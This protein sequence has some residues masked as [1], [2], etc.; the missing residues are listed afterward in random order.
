M[1]K[2]ITTKNLAILL[3]TLFSFGLYAQNPSSLWSRIAP[4]NVEVQKKEARSSL[5]SHFELFNLKTED[6]KA[7]LATAPSR[8]ITTSSNTIITLPTETGVERF[9]VFEASVLSEELKEKFPGIDSYVAQGIDD[10]SA[11]AR[12]SV[13]KVGVHV[14]ISSAHRS[15]YY[16]DPYTQDKKSYIGYAT[17]SLP[18]SPKSF[19]CLVEDAVEPLIET[20]ADVR[21]ADDGKL[22]TFRL[23]IASTGEYAQFH[24]NDQGVDPSEPDAVKKAAVLSAMNVTM[25]RVNG[26][27]ERDL[28]VTMVLV[29]NNEDIIYL[30][31]ST[32]PFTNNNAGALINQSQTAIDSQIGSSNYDIG[33]TF[34]TGAGG[35]A[36][37]RVPCTSSKAR[38]VTGTSSPKGDSYDV[39]FVAHEMG[40][41]FGANHTF[42]SSCS[43]NRNNLTAYEPGSGSTIMAYA[44]VCAP[45]NIQSN[46]DDYFHAISIQEMWNNITNGNSQCAAQSNTNN[47]PPTADAGTNHTIPKSTP[48]RL[49]ATG[50][51]P[52]GDVLSYTWEQFDRQI[53][54]MPPVNT[55]TG[56]PSF[57]SK[58]PIASPNRYMPKLPVVL[59]GGTQTTWE[60]LPSV[61]RTLRFRLTVRDNFAGG[62][63][64]ASDNITLTVD[65][66]SG[67]FEITSQNSNAKWK[68]GTQ[69]TITWDVA[70]TDVAPV[71][72]PNVD[73]LL[74]L[75]GMEYDIILAE[76]TPNDG[77]QT[78]TVPNVPN[79]NDA[80]IMIIGSDNVFF[81][82][83]NDDILID[84]NLSVDETTLENFN[85]WPNPTTGIVNLEFVTTASN[86][87]SVS[88]YDVRG[89][90]VAGQ[91]YNNQGGTF[92]E[93]F[94][95][96][97]LN[98][99]MYF[100]TVTN[101]DKKVTSKLLKN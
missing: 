28:A 100:I 47:N 24:L 9:K 25:T 40:H 71:N 5:P 7:I 58:N 48:F 79:S 75:D 49:Q 88:I 13:S 63:S 37:L 17:A 21:N 60:V 77:N 41:Q 18:A 19:E 38:G 46:S 34:S 51:D 39:D 78:I 85:L 62:A 52:D 15:T 23:A 84:E 67:P 32:D 56:G 50:T 10:R 54:T 12:F 94:D 29:P 6:L 96:S 101:G 16:I 99:G 44:G 20:P 73:I 87:V 26:I 45:Y 55:A 14:A 61:S 3:F 8:N 57:R 11:I 4:K 89:R 97:S 31:A 36:Q 59:L 35:L 42:N 74:S 98:A 65:G 70:G 30:N 1:M 43:G 83:N 33:H 80:R 27:Y 82:I 93:T 95:Y 90:Q 81:D 22:R 64:S 69:K 66:N 2:K 53:A 72:S 91:K 92:K 86:E 68:Q 76:E